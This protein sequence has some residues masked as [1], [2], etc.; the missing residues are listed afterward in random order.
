MINEPLLHQR[1]DLILA[2]M[3]EELRSAGLAAIDR[4]EDVRAQAA[5]L[6]ARQWERIAVTGCGDSF[7][8][9]MAMRCALE[10]LADLPV[11]V[12]PAMEAA[13]FPSLLL[14]SE[15]LLIGI[16][17][18]G[19]VERTI[20]AVSRHR[21]RGGDALAISALAGGGLSRQADYSIAT[22]LRGTTGP[23]PGTANYLGSLIAL[24][25]VGLEF[26]ARRAVAPSV[27]SDDVNA[28]LR[29]IDGH[30]SIPPEVQ[31]QIV[32]GLESPFFVLGSGP[33][34]GTATYG[35]AKFLEAA[36]S[37]GVAQ[38]LEEWAHE[39]YFA[40]QEGTTVLIVS[41]MANT[42]ER[43]KRIARSVAAVGGLPVTIGFE[44]DANGAVHIP[45][46]IVPS[47]LEPLVAWAP[48]AQ[49]AVSFARAHNRSPFGIDRPNRMR[50]VDD[51]IYVTG[52]PSG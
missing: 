27:A 14:D 12:L 15:C 21:A 32:Q 4:W 11:T 39:Q 5:L 45:L 10:T 29:G 41:T 1:P 43:A 40:T 50:T 7:Y 22:G 47:P 24:T 52:Q 49:L 8:A 36:A 25:A 23:V 44:S 48:L 6:P 9:G 30:L 17:V 46:P 18:S 3:A 28:L 16:S 51:D 20:E 37:V 2:R 34:L 31:G 13:A 38:D 35:V 33:D 26:E 42:K 19:K